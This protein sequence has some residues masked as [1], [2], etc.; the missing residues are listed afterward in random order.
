MPTGLRRALFWVPDF[1]VCSHM[2]G[3]ARELCGALYK[4]TNPCH[5]GSTLI[6]AVTDFIFLGF[7]ITVAGECSHGIKI[8]FLLG[9]KSITNLDS[10]LKTR[11]ITWPTKVHL[12]KA[13]VFP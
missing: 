13:M 9:R 5:K 2:A 6:E 3:G 10:R 7:K 4:G 11:A 1:S 8:S 12:V